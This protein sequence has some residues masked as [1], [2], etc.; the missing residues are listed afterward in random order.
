[1]I[2]IEKITTPTVQQ[3][4]WDIRHE[5]F[6]IGQNCPKEIEYEFEEESIHFIAYF[7]NE[8]AGT[9][10]I[11]QT[12]N[13]YKLERFAVLENLEAMELVLL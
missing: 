1:M 7:N 6:V 9:A 13:G 8:P 5:V 10:R 11:R 3:I 2:K 4:A 12:E